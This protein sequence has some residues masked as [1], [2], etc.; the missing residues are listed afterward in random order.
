MAQPTPT[1]NELTR[2]AGSG[3]AS[4]AGS[5][6]RSSDGS[7]IDLSVWADRFLAAISDVGSATDPAKSAA[8]LRRVVR[9][10]LLRFTDMRDHPEKFFLAHR[11]LGTIGLGGFGI[12]FTVQFNLFAGSIL[13]LGGTDQVAKLDAMQEAGNLGCFLLTENQAGV[14]SGLIVKTTA[15]WDDRTKEFVL[16]TPDDA[17]AKNWVSPLGCE[18]PYVHA[19]R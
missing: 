19:A 7:A 2:G 15:E 8:V 14:L 9:T 16:H 1:P 11:L 3:S 6:P 5:V 4:D 12:R 17:A 13:G 18:P 10:Q